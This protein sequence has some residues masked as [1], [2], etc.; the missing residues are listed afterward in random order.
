MNDTLDSVLSPITEATSVLERWAERDLRARVNGAY[1]GDHARIKTAMNATADALDNA[2]GE[3][4]G[5]V[6]QVSAAGGQ[7]A[8]GSQSLA[9]G[10][11]EQASSL[12][13]VS[14]SLQEM[15]SATQANAKDAQ[16]AKALSDETSDSVNTG[17]LRM[18]E[19]T[20]AMHAIR[21]GSQQTAKIVR[22]ID[23]IAFQTNL[24]ALNAA[25]EAAR[26]GD[27]G[28][29]FAVVADEVRTLAIR[30]AEAAR[31]TTALIEEAGTRV[32]GGVAKNAEVLATLEAIQKRASGVSEVV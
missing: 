17:M 25:V 27:A 24:L 14:A 22:T 21:D 16:Q 3:I 19:L 4:A 8:S 12:E 32:E 6:E 15:A 29:G 1:N 9:S 2:L 30:A 28:R 31:Q 20:E 11:S 26:A 5:A 10:S 23:E 18:G 7:I 13:E